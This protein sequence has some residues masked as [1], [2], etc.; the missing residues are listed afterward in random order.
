MKA[1]TLLRHAKAS[2]DDPSL[3]DFDRPLTKRGRKEAGVIGA[4][5][6]ARGFAPDLIL[7][8]P[9]LR[10]RQTLDLVAA[11]L[12]FYP[13]IDYPE[14]L[15]NASP[16]S[17]L[18]AVAVAPEEMNDLLVVGHNP[19]LHMVALNLADL[20]RLDAMALARL[21]GGFP[22]GAV[23]QFE[24]DIQHWPEI[25]AARASLRHFASPKEF[26]DFRDS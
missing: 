8:S 10:T 2:R 22:P 9:S 7:C 4:H 25:A 13:R 3:R 24:I 6:A 11:C 15:Y 14:S 1:L 20:A 19:S 17:L 23:A 12:R 16:A 21:G 18:A 26:G 5:L